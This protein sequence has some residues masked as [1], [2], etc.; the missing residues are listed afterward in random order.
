[1]PRVCELAPP[2]FLH[3]GSGGE[4]EPQQLQGDQHAFVPCRLPRPD[5]VELLLEFQMLSHTFL[6][7]YHGKK[8]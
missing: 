2:S 5:Q 1:M 8:T 7:K 4:V 6:S 3:S